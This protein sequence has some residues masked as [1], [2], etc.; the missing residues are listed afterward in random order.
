MMRI[1][2]ADDEEAIRDGIRNC[3]EKE[4]GQFL[5]AG[6]A[7]D[8]EMAF[9]MLMEM[10]PDVLIA[11][12]CMPFMDGL[13]LARLVHRAMPWM[14]IIFLSGYDEFE[15]AQQA[16]SVR[17]DAY[18]L[19]PINAHKLIQVLE[20][21][22]VRMEQERRQY[23]DAAQRINH[24]EQ[25]TEALREY[26]FNSLLSG[27]LSAAEAAE[28]G[29]R[30]GLPLAAKEYMVCLVHLREMTC[31]KAQVRTL[32]AHMFA[33]Q[34]EAT[35]FFRGAERMILLLWGESARAVRER[36]YEVAQ[37]LRHELKRLFEQDMLTAIGVP[38]QRVSALPEA[39]RTAKEAFWSA[40]ACA[41]HGVFGYTDIVSG[42]A[43]KSS[44]DFAAG[45]ALPD[46]LRHIAPADVPRFVDVYFSSAEKQDTQSILYRYYLLMDLLVTAARVAEELG[47]KDI[48]APENPQAVLQRVATLEG[49]KAYA[50]ET[51]GKLAWLCYR[52]ENIRYSEEIQ[53]A[54]EFIRANYHDNNISLHVVAEEVGFS[55]N[56]FSTI[57]SQE[58]GQT[59][60]EY[61]TQVRLEAAK[62]LL[63]QSGS[64]MS[65]IAF[66]VGYSEPHYFSYLFKKHVGMTP[67][68][69]RAQVGGS[70]V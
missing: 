70:N 8:G 38:V 34:T 50:A 66:A 26:F 48:T 18:L 5:F 41:E 49:S 32:A 12:I 45:G 35:Y 28:Q 24:R 14:R 20:E 23:V 57:F 16:V 15:Y 60:V 67:R 37:N 21:V 19:K 64:R 29:Q 39:Y 17:A 52:H 59:F 27:E 54:K 4:N 61:L 68:D 55:P 47:S 46:K 2:I 11:D 40:S 3:I 31:S 1:F 65:D 43:G 9:P 42:G 13:E 7:A 6:E 58:T 30:W 33:E 53:H 62:A 51:V 63:R 22:A 56:H 44:F 25:E 10:K 36:A 69:Y